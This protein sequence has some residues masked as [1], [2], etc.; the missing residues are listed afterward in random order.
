MDPETAGCWLLSTT[1][2][3]RRSTNNEKERKES[4]SRQFSLAYLTIPG[5]DPIHQIQIAR[6]AGYDY[7]SLRTIPMGLKGEP[8]VH[9]ED[10]P[11]LFRAVRQALKDC[12]M[13]LLDIEL[14]R[15]RE[16]LPTDYR[17][18]FEK[19]AELGATQVLTSVWTRDHSFVVDRYG[20]LCEQAA[21]FGLTLNL[22]F[23]IVSELTSM[24]QAFALQDEVGADNLKI[25]MDMIYV[26]LTGV[27]PQEIRAADPGRFGII[28]LCDWPSDPAGRETVEIVRGGRVYCGEGAADLK[29]FLEALPENVCAIELPNLR[30]LEL[31]GQAGHARRCLETAKEYFA[32]NGL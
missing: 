25:L 10:D 13:K 32:S 16:D 15:V 21:Q 12:G 4:M 27:T 29:G 3:R 17:P 2:I 11:A 30:E 8:Q 19:G 7:V 14:L 20:A 23:P 9:L 22:E 24:E 5:I 31:R 6:E 18:A 1:S 28:H 26:H